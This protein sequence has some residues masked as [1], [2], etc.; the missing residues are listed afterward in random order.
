VPAGHLGGVDG[1]PARGVDDGGLTRP[2]ELV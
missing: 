1:M 2:H